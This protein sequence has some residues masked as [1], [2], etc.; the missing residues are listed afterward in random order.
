M[1]RPVQFTLWYR[2]VGAKQ[3]G[4]VHSEDHNVRTDD[5]EVW[6]KELLEYFNDTL[7][8]GEPLRA[9]IRVDVKPNKMPLQ[10]QWFK[11]NFV[12]I[13]ATGGQG[14]Y[15]TYRCTD[16]GVTAKRWG[17]G[18]AF[19]PDKKKDQYKECV[20][21]PTTSGDTYSAT[22]VKNAVE[23]FMKAK[24]IRRV[25]KIKTVKQWRKVRKVAR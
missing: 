18:G 19:I 15:D 14:S 12:T 2:D 6:A 4:P 10:H 8:P 25:R 24:Q 3:T 1:A 23:T 20:G 7:K 9:L 21:P 17:I 13:M 5:P 22:A 11:T 16:C